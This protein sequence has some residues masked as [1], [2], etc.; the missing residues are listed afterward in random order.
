M[1]VC[2]YRLDLATMEI[3][4]SRL[5]GRKSCSDDLGLWA[6]EVG[7]LHM[8]MHAML[9]VAFEKDLKGTGDAM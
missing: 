1:R 9:E 2:V 4:L 6:S 7:A 3:L 5:G 8:E